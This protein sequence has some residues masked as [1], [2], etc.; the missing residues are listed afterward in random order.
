MVAWRVHKSTLFYSLLASLPDI[1][2]FLDVGSL[3]GRESFAVEALFPNVTCVAFEPNP[4]NIDVIKAEIARRH[5]RVTLEEFAV[6]NESGITT[7]YVK[8]PLLTTGSH[9]T[10]SILKPPER[11]NYASSTIEVP[12]RRLD[13]IDS[14]LASNKIALWIDVEGAGYFVLE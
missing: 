12:L 5:S 9:G 6:G 8:T 4:H 14:I 7:F 13:G 1:D 2:L 11:P 10:S 3:D